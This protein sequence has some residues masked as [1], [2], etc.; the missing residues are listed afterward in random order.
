LNKEEVKKYRRIYYQ[1]NKG[2]Y[3]KYWEEHKEEKKEHNKRYYQKNKEKKKEYYRQHRE[4][5]L[6]AMKKYQDTHKEQ[7]VIATKKYL[8]SPKGKE[9]ITMHNNK[10]RKKG[11]TSFNKY[12]VD[13]EA[14][15]INN[16]EVIYIPKELHR[17]V[18]HNLNTG[19]GMFMINLIARN[20]L[21]EELNIKC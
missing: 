5:Y 3:R 4:K 9:N 2:Y 7:Y 20:W 16:N 18:Y 19:R 21:K 15:H 10:R 13:S 14:H 1:K 12:F 17:S 8:Q 11:F 6:I